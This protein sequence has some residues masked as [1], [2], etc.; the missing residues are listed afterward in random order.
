MKLLF[1][2]VHEKEQKVEIAVEDKT[3]RKRLVTFP[4]FSRDRISI[5][6]HWFRAVEKELETQDSAA[7]AK[8]MGRQLM[9]SRLPHLPKKK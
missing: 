4:W 7:L 9:G 1:A 3:G 6:D 2:V 8:S 5:P